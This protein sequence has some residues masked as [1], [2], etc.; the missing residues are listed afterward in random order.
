MGTASHLRLVE[1]PKKPRTVRLHFTA[2]DQQLTRLLHYLS[3]LLSDEV[4][5]H[6]MSE[7]VSGLLGGDVPH[8]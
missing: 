5:A 8:C 4:G 3:D 2:S 6:A 1:Q 7:E